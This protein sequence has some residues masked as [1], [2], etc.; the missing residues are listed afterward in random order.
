M[1]TYIGEVYC[2]KLYKNARS[3]DSDYTCPG[4]TGQC[5]IFRSNPISAASS[6]VA[7]AIKA[8][9]IVTGT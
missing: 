1:L 3:S 8:I 9:V 5:D 7:K 2:E 4:Y 6:K